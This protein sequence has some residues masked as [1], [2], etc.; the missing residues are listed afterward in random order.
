MAV[1][2]VS[3]YWFTPAYV[4]GKPTL[5]TVYESFRN[6]FCELSMLGLPMPGELEVEY[7][8]MK[9]IKWLNELF[10]FVRFCE[11]PTEKR[12]EHNIKSLKYGSAKKAGH[13]RGRWYAKHEAWRSIRNKVDGDFVEPEYNPQTIVA[14]DLADIERHNN[15]LHP[16]QKTY[17]GMTRKDVFLKNINPTLKPIEHRYLYR[18]IGNE[19]DCTIYNNDYVK[20]A[21]TEFELANFDC[22][23][24]LKP[25]NTQVTAY[26]LPEDDGC[27]NKVYVYQ[28]DT[29]IGEAINRDCSD[30]NECAIERT[31][32]DE[33]AMLHQQKRIAKFDK[34]IRDRKA[35]IPKIGTMD[36]TISE[37]ISK[38]P[39]SIVETEQPKGIAETDY[40]EIDY[41]QL[42]KQQL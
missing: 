23:K 4:V 40:Q 27:V 7:H 38:V 22:L 20:A 11:S 3:G 31:Q 25:N 41:S 17:P 18:F 10:P 32:A 12:A 35:D 39:F 26:W 28:G 2:V 33:Y 8:L 6:M 15:S 42:A 30:Y 9:D 34:K 1:D 14:D 16:L 36:S 13:T 5:Q 19:T 24:R 21:N 37:A 29:Y